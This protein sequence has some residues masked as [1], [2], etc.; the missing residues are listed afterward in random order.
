MNSKLYNFRSVKRKIC[1]CGNQVQKSN[2]KNY[3][4]DYYINDKRTRERIGGKT[5]KKLKRIPS[6]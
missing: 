6:C 2:S 4:I 5:Q 1:K 3:W